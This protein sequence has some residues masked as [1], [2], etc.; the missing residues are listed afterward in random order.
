MSEAEERNELA[1]SRTNLAE[2]RTLLANERTFAGWLRTGM[3]SIAVGLGFSAL[4]RR[5]E[6]LWA[7]KAVATAFIL[8]GV[9]MFLTAERR[10]R[11]VRDRMSAHQVKPFAD[12]TLRILAFLLSAAALALIACIW[13]LA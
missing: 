4:F 2:D 13:L 6:P 5:I 7:A 1:E 12:R 3:G 8:A 9:L 10:S 11:K